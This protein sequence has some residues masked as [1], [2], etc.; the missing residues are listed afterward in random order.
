VV[1]TAF[2]LLGIYLFGR[3]LWYP[4]YLRIAGPLTVEEVIAAVG[5]SARLRTQP[6]FDE[7]GVAYPPESLTLLALK[8]SLELE[9]WV[10]SGPEPI[11]I[12]KYE[13]KALSGISGPKLREGDEQVP[14]G[15]YQIE[16]LN[17][18]SSYHLSMKLDYPN[19][20]DLK[21]ARREGRTRPGS[22]IFIHGK[23]VSIGC[24]AM[25]DEAI[26]ELFVLVHDVGHSNVRVAIAPTDPRESALVAGPG[27]AW[28]EDLYAE[29]DGEFMRHV[30]PERGVAQQ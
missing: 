13:I 14:E 27:P 17:P 12:R 6:Y 3:D 15:I 26:E 4:L 23:A 18:N 28:I 25:G 21:H 1:L 8:D 7:A 29:L 2:G 22:N 11:L 16:S 5:P 10:G 30:L 24:L 20:F 9:V 19:E